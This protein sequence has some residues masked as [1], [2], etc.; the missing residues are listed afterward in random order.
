[1]LTWSAPYHGVSHLSGDPLLDRRDFQ[2]TVEAH[3]TFV[4]VYALSLRSEHAFTPIF[5]K[6][7]ANIA[8]A[9]TVG[10]SRLASLKGV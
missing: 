5:E 9:K 6:T 4:V 2:I 3:A 10:A 1:M 8:G 7:C